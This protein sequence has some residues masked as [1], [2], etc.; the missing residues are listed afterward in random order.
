MTAQEHID[1]VYAVMNLAALYGYQVRHWDHAG[2]VYLMRDG[3]PDWIGK[4]HWDLDTWI[5][6][7][8]EDKPA[9]GVR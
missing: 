2:S 7:L 3:D 4:V 1:H 9:R 8:K 6:N 5:K